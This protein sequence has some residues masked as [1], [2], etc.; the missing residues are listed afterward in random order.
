M[1]GIGLITRN[2][3]QEAEIISAVGEAETKLAQVRD[4]VQNNLWSRY[5]KSELEM[6]IIGAEYVNDD[7]DNVP[8]L[9]M[10]VE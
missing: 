10:P 6:A 1:N 5:G 3:P 2:E 7:T 9:V 8:G 4:I